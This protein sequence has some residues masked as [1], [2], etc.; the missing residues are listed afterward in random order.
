MKNKTELP[1]TEDFQELVN[2]LAVYTEANNRLALLQHD[3]ND[4]LMDVL[5]DIKTEYAELQEKM[6]K[7]ESA[8]EL[9]ALKHPEWFSTKRSLKTPYGTVS[10]R[11]G[12]KLEVSNEEASLVRIRLAAEK[13]FP[14][15][16]P[17]EVQARDE[18][19]AKFIRTKEELNLEALELEED[20]FL[21]S[22]GIARVKT[23]NFSA[24]P[25]TL[26]LGKAVKEAAEQATETA[27]AA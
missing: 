27:A 10:L 22:L 20:V 12:T 15:K 9:I 8:M 18:F 6:S 4:Q 25:A 24:K 26:D 5:D 19:I 17:E 2:L 11:R 23:E 1:Q 14:G 13:Q 16:G 21:K 7:A 3:A